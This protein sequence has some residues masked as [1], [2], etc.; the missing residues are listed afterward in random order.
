MDGKRSS[1][2]VKGAQRIFEVVM[3]TGMG[4]GKTGYLRCMI[5]RNCW[6][7]AM[8]QVGS[9]KENLMTMEEIAGSTKFEE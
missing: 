9:V 7:R 2:L 3:R 4:K 6:G 1:D 5:G 8:K